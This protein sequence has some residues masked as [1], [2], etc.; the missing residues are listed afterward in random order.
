MGKGD[1]KTKRGKIYKGSYGNC[2]RKKKRKRILRNTISLTNENIMIFKKIFNKKT[3]EALFSFSEHDTIES[4]DPVRH[5]K[6]FFVV[7]LMIMRGIPNEE[8]NG[9]T[10]PSEESKKVFIEAVQ[11]WNEKYTEIKST[12]IP[13]NL[14]QLLSTTK[15][16]EQE[17]L[18]KGIELTPALLAAFIFESY[19]KYGYK[20]SQ[21]KTEIPQKGV[22][23][24]KM[25]FAYEV[26]ENGN[27]KSFGKTG[28]SDGQLRQAIKHR[29]VTIGKF[30]EKG[31]IWH[32]FFTNYKSLAGEETWLGKNQPHYHY[33]SNSF[34]LDKEKVIKELK[35]DKYNL[36]NLPHIKL[37]EYGNQPE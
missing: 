30:L 6:D 15:K 37:T 29:K 23:L 11:L 24:S 18:L 12:P 22:D 2:T 13:D 7:K 3:G 21:Y 27:V 8:L 34:G 31:D 28:L 4:V 20:L 36:G 1:K 32:C 26:K 16:S 14:I 35:S 17:K 9:K 19:E 10:K 25:P 33:I 5:Y